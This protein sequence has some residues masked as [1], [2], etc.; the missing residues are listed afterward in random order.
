LTY[1]GTS[2]GHH[3]AVLQT[4][5]A[6]L[7][8]VVLLARATNGFQ[9]RHHPASAQGRVTRLALR[10][11]GAIGLL[12]ATP[13][14]VLFGLMFA[15][16]VVLGTGLLV[17]AIVWLLKAPVALAALGFVVWVSVYAAATARNTSVTHSNDAAPGTGRLAST[18][19]VPPIEPTFRMPTVRPI[20]PLVRTPTVRPTEPPFRFPTERTTERLVRMPTERPREPVFRIPTEPPFRT[21][22]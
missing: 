2:G 21:P 4:G 14:L 3:D 19:R 18:F 17:A 7:G 8:L 11:V 6:G 1:R 5:L 22:F 12:S 10:T 13:L 15:N 20:E 16:G 9:Q